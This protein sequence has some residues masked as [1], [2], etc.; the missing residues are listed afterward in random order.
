MP[1]SQ[2]AELQLGR[3]DVIKLY[4]NVRFRASPITLSRGV[5]E[6]YPKLPEN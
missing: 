2:W 5:H 3:F 6:W 4:V 1:L